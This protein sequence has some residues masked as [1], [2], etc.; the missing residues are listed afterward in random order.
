MVQM[1]IPLAL[2]VPWRCRSAGLPKVVIDGDGCHM[3]QHLWAVCQ[4]S[5]CHRVRSV[6]SLYESSITMCRLRSSYFLKSRLIALRLLPP[7]RAWAGLISAFMTARTELHILYR[8]EGIFMI[9]CAQLYCEVMSLWISSFVQESIKY[10]IRSVT[11]CEVSG[12]SPIPIAVFNYEHE[13][14][15][16]I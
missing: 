5:A 12:S 6:I 7:A 9:F 1:N 2:K 13:W 11:D 16:Q 10:Y 14:L 4:R 15:L 8:G 3:R